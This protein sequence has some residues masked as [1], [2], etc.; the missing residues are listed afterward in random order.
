MITEETN[1]N[2]PEKDR[3]KLNQIGSEIA[4]NFI[5]ISEHRVFELIASA[6]YQGESTGRQSEVMKTCKPYPKDRLI[7]LPDHAN[8]TKYL[9]YEDH[10][11]MEKGN[12]VKYYKVP[13]LPDEFM[14]KEVY[15]R[16]DLRIPKLTL[17][18]VC[19]GPVAGSF[20]FAEVAKVT[21]VELNNLI[22]ILRR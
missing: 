15:L 12:S 7:H 5:N 22:P 16:G 9:S 6:W 8:Y 13:E 18:I 1:F 4:Y 21:L 17:L 2:I 19:D 20:R 14:I 10:L 11:L 3:Q